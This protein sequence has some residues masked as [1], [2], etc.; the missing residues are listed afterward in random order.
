MLVL[1]GIIAAVLAYWATT[2]VC[3]YNDRLYQ[4][5]DA[6]SKS[7]NSENELGSLEITKAKELNCKKEKFS[8]SGVSKN[9]RAI[10]KLVYRWLRNNGLR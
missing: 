6:I 4:K 8:M 7:L 2:N 5:K 9:V 3:S 1:V 10:E